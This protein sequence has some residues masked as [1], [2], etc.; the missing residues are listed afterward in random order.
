MGCVVTFPFETQ[1]KWKRIGKKKGSE[2]K[3]CAAVVQTKTE[4]KKNYMYDQ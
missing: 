3:K 1:T 4:G 2:T